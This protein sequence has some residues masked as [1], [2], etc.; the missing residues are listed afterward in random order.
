MIGYI[1]IKKK[2][3]KRFKMKYYAVVV[4]GENSVFDEAYVISANSLME[5]E[6]DI[7]TDY[8]G[9]DFSLARYQTTEITEEE[10]L[11]HDDRRKF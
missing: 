3:E 7:S 1:E 6:S 2:L 10:Y 11:A 8:C 5:V 4:K 9:N